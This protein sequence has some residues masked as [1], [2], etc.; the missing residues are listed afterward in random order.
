LDLFVRD[1]GNKAGEYMLDGG[2]WAFSSGDGQEESRPTLP[3]SDVLENT[4]WE[5]SGDSRITIQFGKTSF[6][7]VYLVWI[8]LANSEDGTSEEKMVGSYTVNDDFVTFKGMRSSGV[9]QE[10]TGALIGDSLI[11]SGWGRGFEFVQVKAPPEET[12]LPEETETAPQ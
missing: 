3:Y 11:I 8:G 9:H 2:S 1:N 12:E 4:A 6:A 7:F 5:A 10:M